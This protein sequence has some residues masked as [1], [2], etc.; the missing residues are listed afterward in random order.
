MAQ[1]KG[2]FIWAKILH[3]PDPGLASDISP[4]HRT[5]LIIQFAFTCEI[6][7]HS[8]LRICWNLTSQEMKFHSGE[9]KSFHLNAKLPVR[10]LDLFQWKINDLLKINEM[11]FLTL[12]VAWP[13]EKQSEWIKGGAVYELFK[14]T[15]IMIS[16]K[17]RTTTP[18]S[19]ALFCGIPL[20]LPDLFVCF[21]RG[22]RRWWR[23]ET[24]CGR[25]RRWLGC[26]GWWSRIASRYGKRNLLDTQQP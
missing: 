20:I 13:P 2:L 14:T 11:K 3:R 22:I 10:W 19:A 21:R 26:W 9:V 12:L 23:R 24:R 15:M 5:Q 4:S 1:F 6:K 17:G 8:T 16:N 18:T 25:R 7:I